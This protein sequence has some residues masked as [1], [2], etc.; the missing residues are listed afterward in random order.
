MKRRKQLLLCFA[1]ILSCI[2][3][4]HERIVAMASD[5]NFSPELAIGESGELLLEKMELEEVQRMLDNMLERDSFSI[6]DTLTRLLSGE[7]IFS[8]ETLQNLVR[9]LF[10]RELE[11]E[12]GFFTEVLFLIFLC[13]I[14]TSFSAAFENTQVGEISFYVSYLFFFTL[15]MNA[16]AGLCENLSGVLE[17]ITEFMKGL[18]PAYFLA[19]A[20]SVGATT[21]AVFYEGVLV[22]AWMV[23]WIMLRV[24]LPGTNLYVLL[25][26]INHMSKEEMLGKAAE[27]TGTLIGWCLKTLLGVMAGM[28]LVRGLVSPVM[29]TLKRGTLGKLAEALPGIGNAVNAVTEVLLAGAVLVRNSLGLV[30]LLA[31]LLVG[32]GPLIHYLFLTLTWRFLAAVAQ[33]VSDRRLVSCMETMGEG[34]MVLFRI[35]LTAEF[36][37]MLVLLILN[38]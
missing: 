32:L 31:L 24:L 14:F 35:F 5:E 17:W 9:S 16:F 30:F 12:R 4:F 29:D 38:A 13:A 37:C 7:N 8:I 11:Q 21:A 36:L 20:A 10:F 28:N 19:V 3:L 1:V 18:A 23:E 25:R 27:L 33:P 26:L 22:L 34:C 2:L 15:C 6:R